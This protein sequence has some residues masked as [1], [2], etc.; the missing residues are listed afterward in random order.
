MP[1]LVAFGDSITAR[2]SD[3][4]R[5]R[6][7]PRLRERL[8]GWTVVNAGVPAHTTRDGRERFERDVLAHAPDFVTILFGANDSSCHRRVEIEEYEWNLTHF[9]ELIG[10]QKTLLISPTLVNEEAQRDKRDNVTIQRYADAV[11]RV[12][13]RTGAHFL[14]VHSLMAA[15]ADWADFLVADG[16]HFSNAGYAFLAGAVLEKLNVAI[17]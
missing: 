17:Y 8:P 7:T 1:T 13:E 9:V 16:V 5:I 10:A 3:E 4:D 2:E 12:A 14:D 6:L 11:R 15:R